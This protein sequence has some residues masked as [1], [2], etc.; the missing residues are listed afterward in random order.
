MATALMALPASSAATA[1]TALTVDEI[2]RAHASDV[3]RW[4]SRLGGPHVDLEDLVQEVF[5]LVHRHLGSYRGEAKLTTWLY[6]ITEN[7]VRH[8]RRRERWRRL[9]GRS[10]DVAERT[11]RAPEPAADETIEQRQA[12]ELLYRA[13]EGMN[14]RYRAAL[15]LFE[16][17][18]RPGEEVAELLDITV[19]NL[20]VLL[21]RA[22]AELV[23]RVK[24]LRAQAVRRE[25]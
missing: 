12:R 9:L 2:Y 8:H 18:D 7:C 25:G 22:R 21:H 13:M 16:I 6:R 3:A 10:H 24:G 23:K 15:I 5:T 20:W 4:V 17:D 11:L 1:D 19:G 14:E